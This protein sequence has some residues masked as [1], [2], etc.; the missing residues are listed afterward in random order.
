MNNSGGRWTTLVNTCGAEDVLMSDK[1]K[2]GESLELC[3]HLEKSID[4]ENASVRK[5]ICT[6]TLVNLKSGDKTRKLIGAKTKMHKKGIV[7]NFCPFCGEQICKNNYK[8]DV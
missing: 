8:G 2:L 3:R 4:G 6:W 1:C 5:G 7:F